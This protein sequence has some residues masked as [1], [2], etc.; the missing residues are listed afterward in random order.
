M[1]VMDVAEIGEFGLID[2]LL[3][4]YP[5]VARDVIVGPGDDAAVWRTSDGE[6]YVIGTTDTLVEGIHFLSGVA[7]WPDVGYKALAV[8]ASDVYAMG[9]EP[10][11]ALVTLGLRPEM[12]VGD[13]DAVYQGLHEYGPGVAIIGGDV[14]RSP[15]FFITVALLGKAQARDGQP[16][17]LRRSGARPGDAIAVTGT[18]GDSAGGLRRLSAGAPPDDPLVRAHLRPEPPGAAALCA[19]QVGVECGIDVSDGL[20][21]DVGHLCEMSG[22]GAVLHAGAIPLSGD[23]RQAFPGESLQL[24][25]TGGEDYQLVLVGPA[26][27]LSRVQSLSGVSLTFIGEM[28]DD[29]E[30]R[31]RLLDA[32]G[33]EIS[34]QSSGWDHLRAGA[35][36]GGA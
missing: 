4:L 17:L 27:L 16:L 31:V 36:G 30:K 23:L 18:L 11:F 32:S 3:R 1:T 5:P 6:T 25:C 29:P 13:L 10:Q 9:G 19:V 12:D 15:V 8:N 26:G 7:P 33:S 14:V 2:R 21:Q 35:P 24:A 34:F 20:L 28:T 22:T